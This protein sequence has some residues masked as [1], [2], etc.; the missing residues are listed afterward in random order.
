MYLSGC[1]SGD[2]RGCGFTRPVDAEA[3]GRHGLT[4][5]D[6][7]RPRFGV[8]VTVVPT[9]VSAP[10]HDWLMTA[11]AGSWNCSFHV[12]MAVEPVF[13]TAVDLQ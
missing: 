6:L 8:T 13:L 10:D 12:L 5:C 1:R 3:E 4:R 2:R 11:V 9:R 7:R